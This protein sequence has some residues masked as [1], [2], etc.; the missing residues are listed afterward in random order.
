VEDNGAGF[1]SADS[2]KGIGLVALREHSSAL[3]GSCQITSGAN[4]TAIVVK[5]PLSED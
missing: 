3:G 1:D 2:G 4:G 5:L